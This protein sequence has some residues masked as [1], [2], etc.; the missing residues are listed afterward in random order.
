MYKADGIY[1]YTIEKKAS[2]KAVITVITQVDM[3]FP[4]IEQ[5]MGF[6][7]FQVKGDTRIISLQS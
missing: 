5:I 4:I 6:R 3:S 2:D 7:F 1:C